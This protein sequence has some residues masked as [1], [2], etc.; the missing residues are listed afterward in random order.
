LYFL[1]EFAS[2]Y[3]HLEQGLALY[4]RH[5]HHILALHYGADPGVVCQNYAAYTSWQ[6]GFP[7]QGLQRMHASHQLAQALS[8]PFSIAFD[9]NVAAWFHQYRR[10]AHIVEEHTRRNIALSAEQGFAQ[11]LT[12]ATILQGWAL[13]MRG[14]GEEGIRHLEKGL[15]DWQAMAGGLSRPYFLALLAEAYG[16]VGRPADGLAALAEAQ[17]VADETGECWYEAERYRLKGEL[18]LAQSMEHHLEAE[19]CLAMRSR[20]R[21]DSKRNRLNCA[22]QRALL[23]FGSI[24]ESPRMRVNYSAIYTAGSPKVLTRR[25]CKRPRRFWRSCHDNCGPSRL[26][27]KASTYATL[28]TFVQFYPKFENLGFQ[29]APCGASVIPRGRDLGVIDLW[30]VVRL[31]AQHAGHA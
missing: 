18:L 1:G 10:E 29:K 12:M 20:L 19:A 27:N 25:T 3:E 6:L 23:D 14:E 17:R 26:I 31:V 16:T 2:A 30:A 9:L 8:H 24:K 13:A 5:Q 28:R 21:V 4:D 22:R 7:E 15:S 11:W